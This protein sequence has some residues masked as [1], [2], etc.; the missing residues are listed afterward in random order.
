VVEGDIL[1]VLAATDARKLQR[2]T[3]HIEASL[4][5]VNMSQLEI[6]LN[7]DKGYGVT[8]HVESA[9]PGWTNNWAADLR[10]EIDAGKRWWGWFRSP[11]GSVALAVVCYALSFIAAYFVISGVPALSNV[12]AIALFGAAIFALVTTVAVS[13]QATKNWLFPAFEITEIGSSGARRTVALMLLVAQAPIGVFVN[14]I[15]A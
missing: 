8:L 1:D 6:Q 12:P 5:V 2:L 9:E 7:S 11:G 3:F 15:S 4:P 13:L 10:R 14:L